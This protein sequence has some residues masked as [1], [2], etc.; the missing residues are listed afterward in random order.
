MYVVSDNFFTSPSLIV[1]LYQRGLYGIGTAQNDRKGM[2]EVP[3]D[4][5]MKR[6]DFEY[7]YSNKGACCKWLDRRK[8]TMVSSNVEGVATTPTV[9]HRQNG[10]ASKI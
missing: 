2:L 5:K 8:L 4:K 3:I 7:L 6:G 9:P 10:S 1:K